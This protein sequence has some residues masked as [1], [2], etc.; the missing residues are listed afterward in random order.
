MHLGQDGGHFFAS[1]HEQLKRLTRIEKASQTIWNEFNQLPPTLQSAAV[2]GVE[3]PCEE[4]VVPLVSTMRRLVYEITGRDPWAIAELGP[5]IQK[6]PEKLGAIDRAKEA[7]TSLSSES[8]QQRRHAAGR[9]AQFAQIAKSIWEECAGRTAPK[10]P[11]PSKERG[12]FY[13]FLADL[14]AL[15]GKDWSVKRVMTAYRKTAD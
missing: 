10:A 2:M 14:I 6:W 8:S 13:A 12:S 15:A 1:H 3:L 11:S 7:L 4:N 9:K 5:E